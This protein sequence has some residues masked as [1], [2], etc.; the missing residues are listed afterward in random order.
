MSKRI[1]ILIPFF[2][3]ALALKSQSLLFPNDYFFQSNYLSQLERDT[4]LPDFHYGMLPHVKNKILDTCS[5]FYFFD[6]EKKIVNR[7]LSQDLIKVS[8]R[9]SMAGKKIQVRFSVNPVFNLQAGL[10]LENVKDKLLINTRGFWVKAS[11]GNKVFVESSFFENQAFFPSYLDA[12]AK[13]SGVVSG[14]GRWKKFKEDGYD[15]AMSSAMLRLL[16]HPNFEILLGHGKQ[17]IGSSYRSLLLSDNAFNYPQLQFR[18]KLWR[19][20]IIYNQTYAVLM[21]LSD[22]GVTKP[23][24]TERI[25]Q[26]KPAAFQHLSFQPLKQI[27]I[28][29]FQGLFWIPSDNKNNLTLHFNYFNPFPFLNA[30]MYDYNSAV[31]LMHGLNLDI[32]PFKY[33][34]L[35]GQAIYSGKDKLIPNGEEQKYAYLAGFRY[36]PSFGAEGQHLLLLSAEY[37]KVNG[38]IYNSNQ[39]YTQNYFHYGESLAYPFLSKGY[40]EWVACGRYQFK[41][42]YAQGKINYLTYQDNLISF[43]RQILEGSAGFILNPCYNLVAFGALQIRKESFSLLP[44]ENKSYTVFS[45]GLR[46]SIYNLYSDN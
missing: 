6:A 3:S 22:G 20:R 21:N 32:R 25:F 41:R 23:I 13:A 1:F 18:L 5:S 44:N 17:K 7:I 2:V 11:I 30:L 29:L 39:G 42:I 10:D 9:D 14:Q 19:N 35:L 26:K 38:N 24:G 16:P 34:H 27:S 12:A 37:I 36:H 45:A 46:T 28:G 8:L 40:E 43:T 4:T 33:F 31:F 15:Y